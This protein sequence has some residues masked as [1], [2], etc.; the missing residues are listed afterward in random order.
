[1]HQQISESIKI[2]QE[3]IQTQKINS[4]QLEIR[5]KD[6]RKKYNQARISVNDLIQDQDS[7]FSSDLA[8]VDTKLSVLNTLLDYF[9][10]FTETPCSF[11]RI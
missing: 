10:V 3:V 6:M 8:I 9:S 11:N 7:L 1:T 2:L 4:R 5:L